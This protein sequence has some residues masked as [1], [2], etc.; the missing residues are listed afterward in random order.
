MKVAH[1]VCTY[2]PYKGGMGNSVEYLNKALN[3]TAVKSTVITPLYAGFSDFDKSVIHLKPVFEFGN[4]ASLPQLLFRL[5]KFDII[6]LHYPFYGAHLFTYLACL[7]WRKPLVLFYHMDTAAPGLKGLVFRLNRLLMEPLLLG[8]SKMIIGSSVDYLENS[9]IARYARKNPHKITGIPFGVRESLLE[10]LDGVQ[11]SQTLL[12]VGGLDRA[13]YFKGLH[14]LFEAIAQ[15]KQA[16][17]LMG[18]TLDIVGEGDLR[19]SYIETCMRLDILESVNF[20]GN[21]DDLELKERYR[22]SG[23]LILPSTTRGEAFGIVLIEAMVSGTPVI[24]SNL[25]G[26]R[27]VFK[28][29]LHGLQ[30]EPGDS[31]GLAAAIGK[32][33]SDDDFRNKAGQKSREYALSNYT[34]QKMAERIK[35]VYDK[36]LSE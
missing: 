11:K 33:I 9:F 18:W 23:C 10:P 6:H 24:A 20:L 35:S 15:L 12:F 14:V 25:P 28:H 32:M 8:Y 21:I 3:K 29:K 30:V 34:P 27:S 2:P 36:A 16:G 13:H 19:K 31:E 4:A 1:L 7:I 26:V 22:Q 5:R 17:R